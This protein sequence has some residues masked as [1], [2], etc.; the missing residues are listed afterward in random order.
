MTR[1]L[2]E[3]A[4]EVVSLVDGRWHCGQGDIGLI[5]NWDGH[6]IALLAANDF[7]PRVTSAFNDTAKMTFNFKN[8]V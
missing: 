2:G 6:Q 5:T 8:D 3:G 7:A 4:G 1:G